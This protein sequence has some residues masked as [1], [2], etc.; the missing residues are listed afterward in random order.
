MQ[1]IISKTHGNKHMHDSYTVV[2]EMVP[3][4]ILKNLNY[5]IKN[6]QV[7]V[8]PCGGRGWKWMEG[9][10]WNMISYDESKRFPG[11]KYYV[12]RLVP[13]QITFIVLK[14]QKSKPL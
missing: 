9:A 2:K 12:C 6:I 13:I 4:L 3:L 1:Y 14:L 7:L 5:C 11:V 10:Q 8:D